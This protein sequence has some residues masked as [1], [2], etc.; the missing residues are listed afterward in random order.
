MDTESALKLSRNNRSRPWATY[1]LCKDFPQV[2]RAARAR[3][4]L[5]KQREGLRREGHNVA[6][7]WDETGGAQEVRVQ[8]TARFEGTDQVICSATH[9]SRGPHITGLI[10]SSAQRMRRY[11]NDASKTG[12]RAACHSGKSMAIGMV[13]PRSFAR[14]CSIC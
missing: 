3:R 13:T 4:D 2:R 10:I 11:G 9:G 7:Y 1:H 5:L 14:T 8:A 6:I 12:A